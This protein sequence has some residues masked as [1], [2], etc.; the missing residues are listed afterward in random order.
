MAFRVP[1]GK[2]VNGATVN[3]KP[4]DLSGSDGETSVIQPEG[5][6]RLEVIAHFA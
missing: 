2:N 3:G 4:L 5:Q 1:K 6:R